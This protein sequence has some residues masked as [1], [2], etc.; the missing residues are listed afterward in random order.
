MLGGKSLGPTTDFTK[1]LRKPNVYGRLRE[2]M[3]QG[4]TSDQMNE[5]I[6]RESRMSQSATEVLGNSK[7]AQRAQDD[8]ELAGRD[9]AGEAYKAWRSSGGALNLGLD[10]LKSGFE[11][12]FG[13]RDDMALALAKRL[14]EANPAQQNQILMRLALRMGNDRFDRFM[15]FAAKANLVTSGATAATAGRLS[16]GDSKK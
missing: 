8:I 14:T 12:Y 7:T 13:F 15:E 5:I 6:R 4:K 2:I 10:V 1:D 3:P 11:R 9:I 16:G